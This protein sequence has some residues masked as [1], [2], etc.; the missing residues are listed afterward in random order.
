MDD[1][2]SKFEHILLSAHLAVCSDC[3]RFADDVSWQTQ[4]LRAAPLEPISRSVTIPARRAAWRR[5]ALGV[6]TA[7]VAASIAALAIGLRGPSATQA[8]TH[9][10][11]FGPVTPSLSDRGDTSGVPR[12]GVPTSGQT[13]DATRGDPL[14]PA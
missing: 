7:A 12:G 4:G 14:G 8:P 5:P 1:E 13:V 3:R 6:S 11:R 2:L 9:V 10:P